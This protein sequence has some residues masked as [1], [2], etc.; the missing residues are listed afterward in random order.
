LAAFHALLF[1]GQLI[2]NPLEKMAIEEGLNQELASPK[3]IGRLTELR[4]SVE[5]SKGDFFYNIEFS[6]QYTCRQSPKPMAFPN[7]QTVKGVEILG[8]NISIS[9]ADPACGE[10]D[11]SE[12]PNNATPVMGGGYFWP[13]SRKCTTSFLAVS[14]PLVLTACQ[15]QCE[16]MFTRCLDT[17]KAGGTVC[18]AQRGNC[19]ANCK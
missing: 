7:S 17:S 14:H 5:Q 18:L 10:I 6:V 15:K 13:C 2:P 19:L 8:V 1:L 3:W 4:Q 12:R 16:D 11:P 9:K